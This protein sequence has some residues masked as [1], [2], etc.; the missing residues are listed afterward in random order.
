[1]TSIGD[2]VRILMDK[3]S[4]TVQE[5]SNITTLKE[6]AILNIIYNRSQKTEYLNRI[7]EALGIPVDTLLKF[8]KNKEVNVGSYLLGVKVVCEALDSSSIT[9]LPRSSL[10]LYIDKAYEK[11]CSGADESVVTGYI[12]GII[13][14][15]EDF[16]II[17]NTSDHITD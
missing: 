10:Q 14:G 15:H 6:S 16:G 12:Q 2:I 8:K 13:E 3:R 1:M 5:L 7:A 9:N 4:L 11:I 17:N